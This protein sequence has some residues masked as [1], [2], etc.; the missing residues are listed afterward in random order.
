MNR[1]LQDLSLMVELEG[2]QPGTPE[3]EVA[4]RR[5]KVEHC[6]ELRGVFVCSSCRYFEHC[7]L[8]REYLRDQRP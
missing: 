4:L 6:R 7:A 1:T 3:F 8:V 2:I 5:K